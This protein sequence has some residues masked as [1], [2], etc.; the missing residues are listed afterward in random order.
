MERAEERDS[1]GQPIQ[2]VWPTQVLIALSFRVDVEELKRLGPG[3]KE[4][5]NTKS[6][7][8]AT[9][10]AGLIQFAGAAECCATGVPVESLAAGL[11]TSSVVVRP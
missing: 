11:L 4:Q 6:E 1:K 5:V 2:E 9:S 3:R 7:A 8:S 10:S